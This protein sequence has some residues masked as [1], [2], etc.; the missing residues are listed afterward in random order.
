[1]ANV[2]TRAMTV[3]TVNASTSTGTT[4]V[5]MG[6]TR[7]YEGML[8]VTQVVVLLIAFL[9]VHCSSLWTDYSAYRFFEVVTLWFHITF[10][11]FLIMHILQLQSKLSCI[12]WTMTEFLHYIIG[13]SLTFIASTVA[14]VK[15]YG[16]S[17]LVAGSV[18]GFIA[19]SLLVISMWFSYKVTYGQPTTSINV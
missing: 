3:S 10:L 5:N 17:S 12:N 8:K 1:M 11:I 6:Y 16:L 7:S 4:W 2:S 9:C 14:A 18:F 13:A 15:S 19:T